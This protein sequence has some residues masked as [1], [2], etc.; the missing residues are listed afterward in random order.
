VLW[1]CFPPQRV[2]LQCL[3]QAMNIQPVK[4]L[5][6]EGCSES[7]VS[8]FFSF[9]FSFFFL[10]AHNLRGRCS[11]D[12][13]RGWTFLPVSHYILLLYDR[14][15]QRGCVTYWIWHR[16]CMKQR[17]WI[18]FLHA[19]KKC[20]HWH[21]WMLT[22]HLWR[23]NSEC[24]H[25]EAMGGAFQQWWQRQ[26]TKSAGTNFYECSM[27]ALAHCWWKCLANG[28]DYIEK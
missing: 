1:C 23:Q 15:Q 5:K 26:W 11:W 3:Y 28:G 4:H 7:N 9:S 17:C 22:E 10:L 27:Q 14:W 6:Y 19:E 2:F 12:G 13:S 24:E 18:G 25:S 8:L 20:T 21:S 16:I